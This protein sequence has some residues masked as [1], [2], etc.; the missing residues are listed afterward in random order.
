MGAYLKNAWY[1]AAWS[2]EVGRDLLKRVIMDQAILFYR[3]EDGTAVAMSNRCG[4]RFAPL[5]LGKLEGDTVA[6]PYHGIR[7]DS[8]G[9]CVFNPNGNQHIPPAKVQTFPLVERS[10]VLWIWPGEAELADP[11]QL[12]D[13][14]Y[15]EDTQQ[16][17][18]VTG[19]LQVRAN[20]RYIIDNLLDNA[21]LNTVHHDTLG[22]EP[23]TLGVPHTKP[24][25]NDGIWTDID[26]PPG[27]PGAIWTQ[28]WIAQHGAPPGPMDHWVDMGW[29]PGGTILQEIGITPE[30][31]P[32]E[33]GI[34]TL[35]CHFVTPETDVTSH[36]FWGICRSF[37]LDNP[38][39][40]EQMK[41]GANY[42]FQHQDEPML[43]AIQ[44]EIGNQDFWKMR[45]ALIREDVSLSKVRRRM[46]ELMAAEG[47]PVA[48]AAGD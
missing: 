3:K 17:A 14:S 27:L 8:S 21:H 1:A 13:V 5:H 25:E 2:P 41:I 26:C 43:A 34:N 37:H 22:C 45:P 35:N 4:H 48:S 28:L 6:C 24:S 46:D 30:G 11:S 15:L 39:L 18:A 47:S 42:A 29:Q 7:Y 10:G 38:M 12:P 36:Y 20:Y 32:R 19:Y 31:R 44:E 40:D 16:Y 9:K 23:F 33:E